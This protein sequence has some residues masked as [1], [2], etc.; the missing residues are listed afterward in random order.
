MA[1]D[2]R[3][4]CF[5]QPDD[6]EEK[7]DEHDHERYYGRYYGQVVEGELD[8]RVVAVADSSVSVVEDCELDAC[9]D[10]ARESA[11]LARRLRRARGARSSARGERARARCPFETALSR[12]DTQMGSPPPSPLFR[13]A[14]V[15]ARS[16]C[17][18]SSRPSATA[19]AS[20]CSATTRRR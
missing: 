12:R 16:C 20:S 18:T 11:E 6:T 17:A 1:C 10:D 14:R 7:W 5:C 19:R 15:R 4:I 2:D 8:G 9:A 13:L 3:P